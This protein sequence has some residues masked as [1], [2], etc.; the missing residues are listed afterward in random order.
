MKK[1]LLLLI[2]FILFS[3][4]A[5]GQ[6]TITGTVNAS[7]LNCASFGS[8]S[9]IYIGDGI[10]TTTLNMDENLD[11]TCL[12]QIEF[13]I[14]DKATV[15]FTRNVDL[16]LTEGSSFVIEQGGNLP[17]NNPCNANK[18]IYIGDTKVASC[19]GNGAIYSFE[20]LMGGAGYYVINTTATPASICGSGTSTL[21][22]T[23]VPSNSSTNYTWYD[24]NN[25]IVSYSATFTTPVLTTTTTYYVEALI[26]PTKRTPKQAVTVVVNSI[27]AQPAIT[28]THPNC[29]TA[30]GTITITA[31]TAPG[32]TYS[33]D[34]IAYTNTTGIFSGLAAG[35]YNVTVKNPAGCISPA[36]VVTLNA[37]IPP[38]QPTLGSV[39]QPTCTTATGT[40][41][42]TNYSAS[43]TYTVSPSAGT[44]ISGNT[45]TAPA[46]TYTVTASSGSCT[47][48]ASG[49][50]SIVSIKTNT[51]NGTAWST[52]SAPTGT[53]VIVFNGN[54][55]SS[56]DLTGCSCQVNS[57]NVVITSG[58]NVSITNGI[59]VSGGSLTFEDNSSL[60][61]IND[62]AVNTGN[63]VYKRKTTPLKQYDYTLWSTPVANATL[64][65]LATN[66][67]FYAY[68]PSINDWV[69]KSGG[70]VMINGQGYAGRAPSGLNYATP[71]IVVTSFTGVPNNGIIT[72]PIIKGADTANLIGNPYPSA[73]DIDLFLTDPANAG[74]VN[75]TIYL[76]THNTAISN[77]IPGD[78]VY[79]YTADDYCKYNL[80]G[81]VTTASR[82]I[83]GGV[84]PTGKIAAGQ[85]FFIDALAS[86]TA[87][88]KNSMRIQ[89]SNNQFF[90]NSDTKNSTNN[91][92]LALEKHRVWLSF[93]NNRGA[94]NETLVGYIQ[95]ATNEL[96][97]L[98][99]GKTM[100]GEN[101]V[102]LYSLLSNQELSIQGRSLP[103]SASDIIPIGYTTT[104]TGDFSI[105][106]ENF[107]GLFAKQDIYLF[108]KTTGQY[109]D[110]KAGDFTFTTTKGTFNNRFELRFNTVTLGVN[111]VDNNDTNIRIIAADQHLSVLSG[112][113][114]ISS[115]EV[116]DLLGKLVYSKKGIHTNK[117]YTDAIPATSQMLI[118]KVTLEDQKNVT[119]K[120]LMP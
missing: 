12:G 47:S 92:P 15:D 103:F 68:S 109:H 14:R 84:T 7:T 17:S 60:I 116:H 43:Y 102:S 9:K 97:R 26:T 3:I 25:N 89:G 1:S 86:G 34:G 67:L 118:V 8:C 104:I 39:I 20:E 19:N 91:K 29:T 46:G 5:I 90:R 21:T 51:W 78:W 23:R 45:V 66:S 27:P 80:T 22:A 93:S 88:F 40:F 110:L 28:V 70:N 73:I 4:N 57:G 107:D 79:N 101:V 59:T 112:M 38:V 2:A 11:L 61:Q 69:P 120:V 65:Q 18:T 16:K 44:S 50:V 81:G 55:T 31:P 95:G 114:D 32:M 41:T 75:G 6:C 64:S 33:I 52:G 42:I 36:R 35:T 71:Q 53:D 63:I 83:T 37:P 10:T 54:F 100:P 117:F 87:T 119:K 56:S 108:D 111:A 48:S 115:I 113:S 94:Y 85:G 99:D 74:I 72:T 105:H 76:W 24:A 82:A 58:N 30:A 13:I 49:S 96:D 77:T 62:N 98:F 106:L